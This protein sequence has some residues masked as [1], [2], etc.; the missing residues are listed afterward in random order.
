MFINVFMIF[1]KKKTQHLLKTTALIL[2]KKKNTK[3]KMC[4]CRRNFKVKF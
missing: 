2:K 4:R 1:K 3:E